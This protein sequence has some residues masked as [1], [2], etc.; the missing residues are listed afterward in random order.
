[1]KS[2]TRRRKDL[3]KKVPLKRKKK[4][5]GYTSLVGV[6]WTQET[7]EECLIDMWFK[8]HTELIFNKKISNREKLIRLMWL[9][10][11]FLS[12]YYPVVRYGVT[13]KKG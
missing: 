7:L 10:S 3:D 13:V 12:I 11:N 1:M 8:Y 4:Q 6:K 2:I 9:S 5:K